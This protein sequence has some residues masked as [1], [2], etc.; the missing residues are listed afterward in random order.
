MPEL[1][2]AGIRPEPLAQYLSALAILRLVGE[3]GDPEACGSWEHEAFV[4]T[5]NFDEDE[6]VEF[7]CRQ[8]RPSPIVGPWN[9]GSG[10]WPKDN[11]EG[12]RAITESKDPRFATYAR[13]IGEVQAVLLDLGLHEKPDKKAKSELLARLRAELSDEALEWIDAALVLTHDGERFP[14]LLG[15]GGNDGRL[16]FSNNFMKR[17]TDLLLEQADPQLIRSYLFGEP[18]V[19]LLPAPVGQF[20]P[21][22]AGGANGTTGFSSSSQVNPWAY[23]LMLEGALVPSGA[24]T[25]RLESTRGGTMAFPF[26]VRSAMV[27][28]AAASSEE[29]RDELWLPL[30]SAPASLREVRHLF[31]EGRAK[32]PSRRAG[33]TERRDAVDGLDFARAIASLGVDRGVESFSRYGFQQRNGLAFFAVPLGRWAVR[34]SKGADLLAE[35]DPWLNGLRGFVGSGKA[36]SSVVSAARHLDGAIMAACRRDEGGTIVEILIAL[37]EVEAT[38][39]RAKERRLKP[40]TSLSA[41]WFEQTREDPSVEYR[42]AA[43]L[44]SA[45]I[46]PRLRPVKLLDKCGRWDWEGPGAKTMTWMASASLVDNLL[47]LLRRREIEDQQGE[48][49]A[50][51]DARVLNIVYGGAGRPRCWASLADIA[52]FIAGPRDSGMD[53][54]RLE[55]LTGGL[56]LIDWPNVKVEGRA[57]VDGP[58]LPPAGFSLLALAHGP[59]DPTQP[60]QLLPA[61]SGMLANAAAGRLEVASRL[62]I[63]R[64]CG[65]GLRFPVDRLGSEP[66]RSRRLAAAL[67]FPLAPGSLERL[68]RALFPRAKQ[69]TNPEEEDLHQ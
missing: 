64:L 50:Y 42:L 44:A 39:A 45:G 17:V 36:P 67:A 48:R 21:A 22:L 66:A 11:T 20:F 16:E 61:T 7:F 38:I 52:A 47:A 31:A 35:I 60:G 68:K 18:G 57:P 15:T 46:R 59:E 12:L 26:A 27:G 33:S 3:Q 63:Q 56:S 69:P 9:G 58:E 53:E 25:R 6:L 32:V 24:A 10:F 14:P 40:L 43:S 51:R 2:L 28:Y 19:G 54:G 49:E 65:V 5:S 1:V 34:S 41:A 13:V 8:Y 23:V 4:L 29:N 30:W 55:A 62:A 37:G